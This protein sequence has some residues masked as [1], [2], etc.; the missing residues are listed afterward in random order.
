MGAIG[1]CAALWEAAPHLTGKQQEVRSENHG[2][3]LPDWQGY[4]G[5]DLGRIR[6]ATCPLGGGLLYPVEPRG[7]W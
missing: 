7:R 5:G 1:V 3:T 6:P 4:F 2:D